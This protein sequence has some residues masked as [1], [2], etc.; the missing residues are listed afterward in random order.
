M[1]NQYSAKHKKPGSRFNVEE[2]SAF[3]NGGWIR[4]VV[5]FT[6]RHYRVVLFLTIVLS[7]FSIFILT[8][9]K[10]NFSLKA[11]EI[12]PESVYNKF[13]EYQSHFGEPET[14]VLIAILKFQE[15]LSSKNLDSVLSFCKAIKEIEGHYGLLSLAEMPIN[16]DLDEEESAIAPFEEL[17]REFG[18]EFAIKEMDESPF[19]ERFFNPQSLRLYLYLQVAYRTGFE[20]EHRMLRKR[21]EELAAIHLDAPV[22]FVGQPALIFTLKKIFYRESVWFIV[23]YILLFPILFSL[24]FRDIKLIVFSLLIITLSTL[25][26]LACLVLA[27][28]QL[29]FFGGLTFLLIFI[30]CASAIFHLLYKYR[31]QSLDVDGTTRICNATVETAPKSFMTSLSTAVGFGLLCFSGVPGLVNFGGYT[32]IGMMLAFLVTLLLAPALMKVFIGKKTRLRDGILVPAVEKTARATHVIIQKFPRVIVSISIILVLGVILALSRTNKL[33]AATFLDV[34]PHHPEARLFNE[35]EEEQGGVMPFYI[36]FHFPEGDPVVQ[37]KII[38]T[39]FNLERELAEKFPQAD[40]D[41]MY[42]QLQLLAEEELD[43][44]EFETMAEGIMSSEPEQIRLFYEG[45]NGYGRIILRI[46]NVDIRQ[47]ITNREEYLS[48][49]PYNSELEWFVHSEAFNAYDSNLNL[50]DKFQSSILLCLIFFSAVL[51]LIMRSW[52]VFFVTTFINL[53]PLMIIYAIAVLIGIPAHFMV[54][55]G[56]CVALGIILDD[57]IYVMM[58]GYGK[59]KRKEAVFSDIYTRLFPPLAATTLFILAGASIILFSVFLGI[60]YFGIILLLS[61]AGGFIFDIFGGMAFLRLRFK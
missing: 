46:K 48:L 43:Y 28:L 26:S 17:Y 22:K 29:N 8:R 56:F 45:E 31:Y 50:A 16:Y 55:A 35:I 30:S 42:S 54:V 13:Q 32:A 38:Q 53:S 33:G 41:G 5:L 18:N 2:G 59:L 9:M 57:S 40:I 25:W 27:G 37:E 36:Y 61:M 24:N 3:V 39:T 60:H 20:A 49:F 15:G 1:G 14:E 23:A 52:F 47:F 7:I 19:A 4:Q 10:T 6:L 21:I 34:R 51:G 11:F 12:Q 58:E 44:E